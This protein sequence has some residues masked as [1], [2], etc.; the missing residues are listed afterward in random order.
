M[1]VA[2]NGSLAV[3]DFSPTYLLSHSA[4]VPQAHVAQEI[5]E[6]RRLEKLGALSYHYNSEVR[7][8]FLASVP[9]TCFKTAY[10]QLRRIAGNSARGSTPRMSRL[11][12][13]YE[14]HIMVSCP[15]R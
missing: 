15:G 14:H 13:S 12:T 3:Y 2:V 11:P 5:Q 4:I 1:H 7:R 9:E 6:Q 8:R 10:T